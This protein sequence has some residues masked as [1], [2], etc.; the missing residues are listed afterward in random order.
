MN[1]QEAILS[2]VCER[3]DDD[4]PRLVFADWLEDNG[5]PQ[6]AE[7]IRAQIELARLSSA[8]ERRVTLLAR[9]RQ[10][11]DEIGERLMAELPDV[12]GL[13]WGA[14]DDEAIP[15]ER[16]FAAR[17]TVERV[18]SIRANRRLFLT[19][20]PVRVLGLDHLSQRG[21]ASLGGPEDPP[22]IDRLD[23][24]CEATADLMRALSRSP[25][26]PRLTGMTHV[27][28][29]PAAVDVLASRPV[30]SA[31]RRLNLDHNGAVNS[32]RIAEALAGST[33]LNGLTDLSLE[34]AGLQD[35]AA[36]VLAASPNLSRLER[37]ELHTNR[38]GPAGVRA[39]VEG[40]DRPN[41]THFSL[42]SNRIGDE[43]AASLA[44]WPALARFRRLN[45]ANNHLTAAAVRSLARGGS[46]D[47]VSLIRLIESTSRTGDLV[48]GLL[49]VYRNGLSEAGVAALLNSPH[50]G[51]LAELG[52][53]SSSLV[54]EKSHAR[55][56]RFFKGDDR[57]R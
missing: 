32:T 33:V 39:F 7:F 30:F 8:D 5:D 41:L 13:D 2:A 42:G 12:P 50:R 26:A 25:L 49:S 55:L 3:P 21:A 53:W 6:R 14:A 48:P 43:G 36:H 10:L 19:V 27:L 24:N 52:L 46:L 37:L 15:F 18:A 1:Q 17:V 40:P 20:A 23:F 56:R 35:D 57:V 16:G 31:L 54:Q 11:W 9:E 4:A 45:L 22:G 28:L 47:R 34:A 51:V 38:I 29:R 44:A